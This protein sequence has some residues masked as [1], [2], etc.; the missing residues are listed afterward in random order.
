MTDGPSICIDRL[1][2][3]FGA[4]EAVS[5]L[6][7]TVGTGE[8]VCFLGPNGAG[9]TT[10]IN[11]VMGLKRPTSGDVFIN[12]VSVRAPQVE[13]VRRRIGFMPQQPVLYDYLTGREFIQF[14]G[15]LY[16]TDRP[17]D[18][19]LEE[20]FCALEMS[21]H[22]DRLIRDYSAGMKKKISFLTA[23]V[24]QPDILLFDEPTG[25]LDALS[26]RIVKDEMLAARKRGS[27]VFFTTHVL[28]V[29]ERLADRIAIIRNGRLV[30]DGTL[31]DLRA[32]HGRGAGESLENIFLRLAHQAGTEGGAGT[33]GAGG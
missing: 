25:T 32:R 15:E 20:R 10:T 31:R 26:A 8:I 14:F 2:K 6:S 16:G 33:R 5:E 19:W 24:H 30:A 17:L 29:A 21:H 22:A 3:S 1:T 4:I 11:T 23:L 27:L 9:K 7:L 18:T 12:G 13:S 28:E